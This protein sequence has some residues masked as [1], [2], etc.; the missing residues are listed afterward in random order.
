MGSV[1]DQL[2]KR[3]LLLEQGV[4]Q[5]RRGVAVAGEDAAQ[6]RPELPHALEL[7]GVPEAAAGE[8]VVV[9]ERHQ[10]LRGGQVSGSAPVLTRATAARSDDSV[11][12]VK[13]TLTDYT[14]PP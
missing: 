4:D 3:P 10:V 12:W 5:S 11:S 1:P 6:P 9:E 8:L 2:G 7:G 14:W 13:S